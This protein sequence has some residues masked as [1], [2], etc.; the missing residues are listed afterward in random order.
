M[1]HEIPKLSDIIDEKP[2]SSSENKLMVILNQPPKESWLREHPTAE[3][4]NAQG[5]WVKLK[6]LPIERIEWLLTYIYGSWQ[7]E[8]RSVNEFANS[9]VVI[10]RL[11]VRNP[12]TDKEEWQDGIG[13]FAIG[14]DTLG[15]QLAAPAAETYAIKCASEKL[16]KI[17]GKDLGRMET[18]DYT[19]LLK[20]NVVDNVLLWALYKEKES[21]LSAEEK[22]SF[23]RIIDNKEEKSYKKVH[24]LLLKK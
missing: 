22:V 2:L 10:V 11:T 8:I 12:V 7:V 15:A 16:G 3:V 4:K 13:A 1:K 19:S 23:S 21:K 24:E 14:K 6:Y 20:S 5:Q 17:F 18:M 9:I